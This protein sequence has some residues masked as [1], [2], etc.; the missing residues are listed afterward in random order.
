[1]GT[2][3]E[4]HLKILINAFS[5]R[6]GGGQTY[7][8]N[9]LEFLRQ[10]D[11]FEVFV[12]APDSLKVPERR[13][14]HR[15]HVR[16]PVKNPMMRAIWEKVCLA[17][18]ARRLEADVLFYPG[19]VLGSRVPPGC[20]SVMTFQNMIPFDRV[21]RRKYPLGYMRVRNWLLKQAM[22]H[23]M[24]EADRVICIS[25]FGRQV[26]ENNKAGLRQ[27]TIVI[28]HGIG[29]CFRTN[30]AP[31]PQWLFADDYLLYVSIL[32]V[33]KAQLEVLRAY[34]LLKQRRFT[35]EKLVLAGPERPRYA[36]KVRN[37]IGRLG[38][39]NDVLLAG[40]VP[41]DQLP[42][43]YQNALI[44]I[45]ASECENCP[46]IMLEALAAG[47]P[48]LASNRPPM[49]EFGGDATI[50]FDPSDPEDLAEKLFAVIDDPPRLAE[51]SAKTKERSRLYDWDRTA[52]TT[53]AAIGALVSADPRDSI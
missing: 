11:C 4:A 7:L 22:L 48:L 13:N 34:A 27:K 43:L 24:L 40:P 35:R 32:D 15:I 5:A 51:L 10:D 46:N 1:M 41:H 8:T 16:W 17:R 21:Q 23:S 52:R 33:Y 38:L 47:R 20:K 12:L 50:Y 37:E 2:N 29:S 45:F 14:I 36:Q 6:L 42:A 53:W 30:Q 44:N 19:G 18:L 49:P 31:R 28:P 39:E 26:I 25:E 9:L 3:R